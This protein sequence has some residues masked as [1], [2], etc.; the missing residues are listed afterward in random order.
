MQGQYDEPLN[1]TGLKQAQAAGQAL[2]NVI[3]H[4][5]HSSDQK[6][7][8]TTCQ[9]VLEG[10]DK[11]KI[12]SNSDIL[13]NQLL[14]ERSFGIYENVPVDDYKKVAD[15]AD[16]DMYEYVPEKGESREDVAVRAKN[17]LMV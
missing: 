5:A 3:F 12:M 13:T 16:M 8:H 11:S 10:N 4:K 2:K 7:A 14:R 9:L 15:A 17:F 6:R 1:D